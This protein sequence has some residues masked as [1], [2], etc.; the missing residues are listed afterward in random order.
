MLSVVFVAEHYF[1]VD[2][3]H[4]LLKQPVIFLKHHSFSQQKLPNTW[5][6]P[7]LQDVPSL[8]ECQGN[9]LAFLSRQLH[10]FL[11]PSL[12][13]TLLFTL[14]NFFWLLGHAVFGTLHMLFFSACFFISLIFTHF[15]GLNL[16]TATSK[17]LFCLFPAVH[18]MCPSYILPKYFYTY[19]EL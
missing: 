15:P 8:L 1:L 9:H 16:D 6:L 4:T 14:L 10:V 13:F 17:N 5:P 18:V 3:S 11:I 12:Y 19:L 2:L 7:Y